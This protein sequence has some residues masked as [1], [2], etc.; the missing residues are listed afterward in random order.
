MKMK[1]KILDIELIRSDFPILSRSVNG[2]PLVYFDN[3]ATSQ[4]PQQ[5]ISAITKYYAF[6]NSN[7]HRGIHTLSQ[8]A[9]AAYEEARR[10]EEHTSELQSH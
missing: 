10:S 4:K 1:T 5:V 7:I 2:K 6:E 9:T 8:Q 3:A